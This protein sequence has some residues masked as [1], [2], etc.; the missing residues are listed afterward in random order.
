MDDKEARKKKFCSFNVVNPTMKIVHSQDFS[1]NI[2]KIR[3]AILSSG[4]Q[5]FHTRNLQK[6]SNAITWSQ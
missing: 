6:G 2:K 4:T 5:S 3:N 1:H